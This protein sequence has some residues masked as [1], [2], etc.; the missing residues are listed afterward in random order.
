MGRYCSIGQ[1]SIIRPPGKIYKGCEPIHLLKLIDSQF[2]YYPVRISDFVHIGEKCI[3]EAA[4][5]GSGVEIGDNS[6]IVCIYYPSPSSCWNGTDE[7]GQIRHY[8]RPS[9]DLAR[10]CPSGRYCGSLFLR[11]VRQPRYV[12]VP[13]IR[14]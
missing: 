9:C 11:L 14:S 5:I 1:D 6:I 3:I 7:I 2:T 10:Y 8:Q 13:P 4:Q 12:P